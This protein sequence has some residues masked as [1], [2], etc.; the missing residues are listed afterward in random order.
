MSLDRRKL[1]MD[2]TED[3]PSGLTS[4]EEMMAYAKLLIKCAEMGGMGDYD[5]ATVDLTV[6]VTLKTL[7]LCEQPP[8][9]IGVF[10]LEGMS[11]IAKEFDAVRNQLRSAM[12]GAES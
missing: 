11:R 10:A 9:M 7:A 5:A 4:A 1:A 6:D 2:S 3:L 12:P 8:E